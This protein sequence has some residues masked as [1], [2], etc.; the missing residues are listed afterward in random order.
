MY[1]NYPI[2]QW[3]ESCIY[4]TESPH[5]SGKAK[6]T[7]NGGLNE[8]VE[9][10]IRGIPDISEN[11]ESLGPTDLGLKYDENVSS[12]VKSN[13]A[14]WLKARKFRALFCMLLVLCLILAIKILVGINT[15]MNSETTET[16]TIKCTGIL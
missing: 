3:Q 5:F 14:G 2:P 10:N 11:R 8:L 6:I 16:S 9:H 1:T 15:N 13:F 12:S 7:R 4:L